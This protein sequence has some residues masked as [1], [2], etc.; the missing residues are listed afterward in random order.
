[1]SKISHNPTTMIKSKFS[2]EV[3]KLIL[4]PNM[5]TKTRDR[6]RLPK[7]KLT[8]AEKLELFDKIVEAHN[9][10]TAEL[11]AYQYDRREKK[12]IK[13]ARIARGWVPK[14]KTKKVA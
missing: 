5:G 11:T 4:G 2:N 3:H 8:D 10:C 1:M 7:K 12:R 9:S 13:K 14:V 6:W